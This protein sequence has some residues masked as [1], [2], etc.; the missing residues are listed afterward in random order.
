MLVATADAATAEL[1]VS[2]AQPAQL[3]GLLAS[4]LLAASL[5]YWCATKGRDGA[6]DI[7]AAR[8]KGT[9]EMVLV[10]QAGAA[11]EEVAGGGPL[12][13]GGEATP[14]RGG[15]EARE[16]LEAGGMTSP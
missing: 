11:G 6:A 8:R 9:P 1:S 2:V 4:T 10:Q 16:G 12:A 14:L 3:G 13:A 15:A 5:V 7:R